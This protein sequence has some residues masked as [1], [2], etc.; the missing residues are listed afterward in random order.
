VTEND[1]SCDVLLGDVIYRRKFFN[2]FE[3]LAKPQPC[4]VGV[5]LSAY[6][7]KNNVDRMLIK[8]SDEY[9]YVV[10]ENDK[11]CFGITGQPAI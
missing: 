9:V 4:S 11:T 8:S 10:S 7:A 3:Q 6:L 1:D 5:W 2:N